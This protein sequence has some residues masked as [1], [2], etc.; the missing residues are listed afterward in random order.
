MRYARKEVRFR[1]LSVLPPAGLMLLFAVLMM[2]LREN[3]K[4]NIAVSVIFVYAMFL[5]IYRFRR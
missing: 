2:L 5:W 4:V 3:M 1:P